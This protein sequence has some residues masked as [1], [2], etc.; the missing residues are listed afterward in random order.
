MLAVG[1]V[2]TNCEV[3]AVCNGKNLE[4]LSDNMIE[5]LAL[6]SS[7]METRKFEI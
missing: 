2:E 1:Y 5:R 4:P 7:I 3:N 6:G